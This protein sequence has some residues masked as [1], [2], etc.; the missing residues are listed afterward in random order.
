M[1]ETAHPHSSPGS[2]A[3]RP[4]AAAAEVSRIVTEWAAAVSRGDRRGVLARHDRDVL[5]FDFP[6]EV[7]GLDAYAR[8]WDFFDRSRRGAVT[9]QPT[10]IEATAGDRIAFVTC[11][12]HCDGTTAGPLDFRLTVGLEKRDGEWLVTHEHHSVRT[13]E[14]RFLGDSGADARH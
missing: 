3:G 10:N 4:D 13:V 7:R 5:M 1:A 12:V 14:S 8:T 9:F 11:M 6:D 2:R